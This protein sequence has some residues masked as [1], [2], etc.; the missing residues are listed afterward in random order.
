MEHAR[1]FRKTALEKHGPRKFRLQTDVTPEAFQMPFKGFK[2]CSLQM[3]MP[4]EVPEC[5][6]TV[7]HSNGRWSRSILLPVV[8]LLY[9]ARSGPPAFQRS[10]VHSHIPPTTRSSH[11]TFVLNQKQKHQVWGDSKPQLGECLKRSGHFQILSTHLPKCRATTFMFLCTTCSPSRLPKVKSH[12]LW[13]MLSPLAARCNTECVHKSAVLFSPQF[14]LSDTIQKVNTS[15][16]PQSHWE[17]QVW[18]SQLNTQ[19]PFLTEWTGI[20]RVDK[21]KVSHEPKGCFFCH[22]NFWLFPSTVSSHCYVSL[23]ERLK[24][25]EVL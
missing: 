11:L 23:L 9:R 6:Q 4:F 3:Y 13:M 15:D 10:T 19:F 21:V 22:E 1:A 7:P 8:C 12:R 18:Y 25:S 17:H 20:Y 2:V 24:S 14:L 16:E 5:H